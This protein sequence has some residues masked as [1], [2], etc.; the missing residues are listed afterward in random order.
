MNENEFEKKGKSFNKNGNRLCRSLLFKCILTVEAFDRYWHD[1]WN[2]VCLLGNVGI[3]YFT[4]H[5]TCMPLCVYVFVLYVRWALCAISYHTLQHQHTHTQ[6]WIGRS[7]RH[8]REEGMREREHARAR[9]IALLSGAA[10]IMFSAEKRER[11]RDN[12][13]YPIRLLIHRR[14]I[15]T[16]YFIRPHN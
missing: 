16:K 10:H 8:A 4:Q 6:R 11:E 5:K 15:K 14:K 7:S 13:V 3:S 1:Y 9:A 2:T 12:S